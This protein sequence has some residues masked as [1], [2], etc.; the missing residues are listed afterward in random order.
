M[1][2]LPYTHA[3]IMMV[4]SSF[5]PLHVG[6]KPTAAPAP[7]LAGPGAATVLQCRYQTWDDLLARHDG[8]AQ[9]AKSEFDA[10]IAVGYWEEHAGVLFVMVDCVT[11][12]QPAAAAT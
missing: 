9:K 11:E 7:P 2:I 1:R 6:P 3:L 5:A 12:P 10:C 4:M 8:D